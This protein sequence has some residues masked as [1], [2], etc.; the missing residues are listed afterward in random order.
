MPLIKRLRSLEYKSSSSLQA[1]MF[2]SNSKVYSEYPGVNT[3][4]FSI[5]FRCKGS[6]NYYKN[7]L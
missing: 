7:S 5:K 4:N 6:I 1:S 3:L 2:N